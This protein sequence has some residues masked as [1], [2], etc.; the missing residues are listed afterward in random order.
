MN[1]VD[2]SLGSEMDPGLVIETTNG[3]SQLKSVH[4]ELSARFSILKLN[5]QADNLSL[6]YNR[7]A[8]TFALG[9]QV[10]LRAV[11]AAG[12]A[13]GDMVVV[14]GD[15]AATNPLAIQIAGA[16]GGREF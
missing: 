10:R 9:G 8:D 14:R 12:M 6:D 15:G 11:N 4:A 3:Q 13:D 7:D 1:R 2:V 16:Q 5:I